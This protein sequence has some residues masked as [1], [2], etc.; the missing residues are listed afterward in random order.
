MKLLRRRGL[1]EGFADR[2]VGEDGS[3]QALKVG[4]GESGYG[5][6]ELPPESFDVIGRGGKQVAAV[7]FGCCQFLELID[8]ELQNAFEF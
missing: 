6:F 5:L 7:E 2:G 3:D 8:F 4:I 1:A